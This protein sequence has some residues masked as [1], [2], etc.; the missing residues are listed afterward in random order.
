RLRGKLLLPSFLRRRTLL[1]GPRVAVTRLRDVAAPARRRAEH[2]A[3]ARAI[4]RRH[5]AHPVLRVERDRVLTSVALA[6]GL[7]HAAAAYFRRRRSTSRTT[8]A[9][10]IEPPA[11]RRVSQHPPSSPNA[12]GSQ[13]PSASPSSIVI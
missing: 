12:V 6:P 4:A 3:G 1:V 2:V 10:G 9:S 5:A 13:S 11:L 8:N 7:G